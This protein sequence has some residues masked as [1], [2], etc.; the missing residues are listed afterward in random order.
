[1]QLMPATC[2][3]RP[4]SLRNASTIGTPDASRPSG[5]HA[6]EQIVVQSLSEFLASRPIRIVHAN[7]LETRLRR[8]TLIEQQRSHRAVAA[9][10]MF[11]EL[12]KEV[13]GVNAGLRSRRAAVNLLGSSRQLP[14]PHV[15]AFFILLSPFSVM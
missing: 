2:A 4:R 6:N 8:Q 13:H 14:S 11:L 10:H 7:F 5:S 9:N 12:F 15:A 3:P 1:M